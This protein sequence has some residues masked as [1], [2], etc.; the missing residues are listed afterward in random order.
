[1]KVRA[2][3][4]QNNGWV[5]R[6]NRGSRWKGMSNLESMESGDKRGKLVSGFVL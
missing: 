1:M 3:A 5:S 4:R 6:G 2:N